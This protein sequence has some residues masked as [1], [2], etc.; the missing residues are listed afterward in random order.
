M[1]NKSPLTF[2]MKVKATLLNITHPAMMKEFEVIDEF[3]EDTYPVVMEDCVNDEHE[4]SI[5]NYLIEVNGTKFNYEVR[6]ISIY[7]ENEDVIHR[8]I[9]ENETVNMDTYK[10]VIDEFPYDTS[11]AITEDCVNKNLDDTNKNI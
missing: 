10:E 8:D 2:M 4:D 6:E 1:E 9:T 7:T 5:R 3:Q 11:T